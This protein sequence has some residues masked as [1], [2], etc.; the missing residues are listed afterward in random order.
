MPPG[1]TR[2]AIC[3]RVAVGVS[4]EHEYTPSHS[5]VEESPAVDQPRIGLAEPDVGDS[6]CRAPLLGELEDFRV[7][8]DSHD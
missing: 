3:R 2:S 4:H 8:I 7:E 1:R 5:G 6:F